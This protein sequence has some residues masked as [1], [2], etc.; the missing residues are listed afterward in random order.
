M[1]ITNT[2]ANP[3]QLPDLTGGSDPTGLPPG[4]AP[5]VANWADYAGN[6]IVQAWVMDGEAIGA[7]DEVGSAAP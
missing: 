2:T 6:V 1:K 4:I 3:L 7:T 5:P